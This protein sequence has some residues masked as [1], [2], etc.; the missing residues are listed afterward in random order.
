MDKT[1]LHTVACI[2]VGVSNVDGHLHDTEKKIAIACLA[3]FC[4][5]SM[6][7]PQDAFDDAVYF[8]QNLPAGLTKYQHMMEMAI[9][10][11]ATLDMITRRTIVS[12]LESIVR[13]DKRL[14]VTERGTV[15][16]LTANLGVPPEH[17][18][19]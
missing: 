2:Y 14:S 9:G 1:T 3:N 4:E 5:G 11:S 7:N 13:A 15:V 18:T 12:D 6:N 19:L 16:E 10:L 17:L 8:W